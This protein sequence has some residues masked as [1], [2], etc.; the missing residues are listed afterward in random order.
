MSDK[1]IPK[2]SI[3]ITSMTMI[4]CML[5]LTILSVLSLST[6]LSERNF[7]QKRAIATTN[8]YDAEA[9]A[10]TIVN[11]LQ[12]MKKEEDRKI[13]AE[14]NGIMENED[15]YRFQV[16]VDEKQFLS[17]AVEI[18]HGCNVICWQVQPADQWDPD[19]SLPVWNG[20]I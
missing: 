14:K 13:F 10:T 7:A 16:P 11:T 5:C 6:A 15:Q 20:E 4:L 9:K 2:I 8:Y 17:V 1:R 3:G 18:D 19:E 12:Q